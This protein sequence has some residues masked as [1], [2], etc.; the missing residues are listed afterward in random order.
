M[1][2]SKILRR[3]SWGIPISSAMA[4]RGSSQATSVTKSKGPLRAAA[5]AAMASARLRRL[6]SRARIARGV[7]PRCTIWRTRVCS[8]GSM[9]SRISR[10]ASIASRSMCSLKRMIAVLV[11]DENNSGCVDTYLTSA[12]RVT[13]Q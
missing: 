5:F 8:G 10:W 1:D 2:H 7:K 9:L 13:A 3:S 4:W 12:C 11:V 6:S